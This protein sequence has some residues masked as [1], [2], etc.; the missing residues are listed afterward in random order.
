MLSLNDSWFTGAN[1]YR[2]MRHF[3]GRLEARFDLTTSNATLSLT[4]AVLS[5]TR[6]NEMD[7]IN[8]RSEALA[9]VPRRY[10]D[11]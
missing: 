9:F 4:S 3:D 7:E 5:A 8:Q 2:Q 10:G 11:R 6:L 1:H